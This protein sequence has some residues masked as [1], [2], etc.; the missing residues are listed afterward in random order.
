MEWHRGGNSGSRNSNKRSALKDNPLDRIRTNDSR[1]V[2]SAEDCYS[3]IVHG[4][5]GSQVVLPYSYLRGAAFQHENCVLSHGFVV[6]KIAGPPDAIQEIAQLLSR[7]RL[8]VVRHGVE[9][10]N[11][12]VQ[13]EDDIV[14]R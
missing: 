2:E 13:I 10:L 14:F 9:H 7:Q 8:A 11:V 6:V 1:S 12:D 4:R 5:D 3:I